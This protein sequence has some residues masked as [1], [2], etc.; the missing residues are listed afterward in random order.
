[1]HLTT[2]DSTSVVEVGFALQE[3]LTILHDGHN[4]S[5]KE[6]LVEGEVFDVLLV[7]LLDDEED[8]GVVELLVQVVLLQYVGVGGDGLQHQGLTGLVRE[9][10]YVV[11]QVIEFLA[12]QEHR[13]V[14]VVLA[15]EGTIGQQS[16]V[17]VDE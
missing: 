8:S 3:E 6:V 16:K 1:M 15:G 9:T 5:I 7:V 14:D 2:R 12:L 10:Q 4:Q 11:E 17:E 13:Q